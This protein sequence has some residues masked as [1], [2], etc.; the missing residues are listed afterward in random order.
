M[1]PAL[2]AAELDRNQGASA[3]AAPPVTIDFSPDIH[4]LS[5]PSSVRA[6]SIRVLRTHLIAQHLRDGRRS[7]AI[8]A[9]AIGTGAS[10][11]SANLAV[12]L[13]QTGV[14]TLLIDADMRRSGL[15]HFFTP[16]RPVP[17]LLD[18][19]SNPEVSLRD[20][21]LEDVQPSLS[22]LPAGSESASAQELLAGS[23]FKSLIDSCVRDYDLTI[24]D[25]PAANSYADARRIAA[26]LRYALVVACRNRSFVKDVRTLI[27]ELTSDRVRVVGTYLN[28]R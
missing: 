8:C 20:T 19:L 25:T 23:A 28:D 3:E 5:E 15:K 17:G 18:C 16:S 27:G 21:V 9:P 24:V 10:Y 12:A 13:A 7:L 22:L 1:A 6:E 26:V 11:L 2:A 14:K 4:I